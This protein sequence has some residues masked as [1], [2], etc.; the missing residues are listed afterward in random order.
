MNESDQI[1]H[2]FTDEQPR[3]PVE[4]SSG[5]RRF[6]TFRLRRIVRPNNG[7]RRMCRS[8]LGDEIAAPSLQRLMC[9]DDGVMLVFR[10]RPQQVQDG[11]QVL[12]L[13]HDG[14]WKMAQQ[15]PRQKKTIFSVNIDDEKAANVWHEPALCAGSSTR[16]Y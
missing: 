15:R 10:Q 5:S 13:L 3:L 6:G 11:V 2:G 8:Q 9:Y 12:A 14:L 7:Y 4:K 16:Q 1:F